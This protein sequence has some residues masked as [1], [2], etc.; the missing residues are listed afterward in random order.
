MSDEKASDTAFDRATLRFY[1]DEAPV[2]CGSGPQ[3]ASRHLASFLDRLAS[4]SRILELGCGG[5]RDAEAMIGRGFAVDATDGTPEIA[6][7][8]EE[9]INQ[10]V[11]VMRFDQLDSVESYD[12]VWAHASLLHVPRP[13]LGRVL[14]LIHRALRPGGL[15]FASFKQ[16]AVEG[17]DRFARYFNFFD[18]PTLLATYR[19]AASWEIVATE[20]YMG[21]GVLNAGNTRWIA[22]TVRKPIGRL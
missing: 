6:L 14:Q 15:H 3:G 8:A 11:R 5:G 13:G 7:K 21:G 16:G 2:Y 4:G 19:A 22:V 12:A 20:E 9:R 1:S 17:R 18:M 10:R